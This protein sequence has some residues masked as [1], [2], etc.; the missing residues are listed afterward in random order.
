MA[1][2]CAACGEIRDEDE[3]ADRRVTIA[4]FGGVMANLCPSCY[5][6]LD[7]DER[8]AVHAKWSRTQAD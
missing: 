6:N 2:V 1:H 4:L 3:I 8:E 7:P 5:R